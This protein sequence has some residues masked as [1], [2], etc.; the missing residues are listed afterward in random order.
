MNAADRSRFSADALTGPGG[1]VSP[2]ALA[3]VRSHPRF[4]EAVRASAGALVAMGRKRPLVINDLGRL[5]IG[6]LALYLHFSRDPADPRSGLSANRM[7]AI[8]IEQRVCSRGRAHAAVALMRLSGHLTPAPSR[9]DRR[10]HLL[11]P[12]ER[13]IA[14]CQQYWEAIFS[15]MELVYSERADAKAA[16]QRTEFLAAFMRMFGEHFRAGVRLFQ[17][18]SELTSFAHRNAGLALLFDLLLAAERGDPAA[19]VRISIAELAMRF[20]VSRAQVL[21]VLDDAVEA[22]LIER[23]GEDGSQ[24]TVRSRLAAATRNFYAFAFSLCNH[25]VDVA[26]DE[27]GRGS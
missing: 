23:S 24:I 8:C 22:A 13:L 17:A 2:E 3:S 27:L 18:G 7:K 12:T 9:A 16:L 26:M 21:R 1:P 6:N 14:A 11:A 20:A 19:P 15:G 4:Q 10:L 25:Y 5:I